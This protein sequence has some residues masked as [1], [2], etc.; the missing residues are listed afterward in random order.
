MGEPKVLAVLPYVPL[1]ATSGGRL[2]TLGLLRQLDAALP[3]TVLA[4]NRRP[5]T[6][7]RALAQTLRESLRGSL[8]V[9]ESPRL[10]SVLAGEASDVLLGRPLRYSPYRRGPLA[11]ALEALLRRER[12]DIVHFDHL[13]TAQ[14]APV[15]RRVA[16]WATVVVDAHN[17]ESVVAWRMS[18]ADGSRFRKVVAKAQ[19]RRIEW[20]ERDV[21]GQADLVLTC[22]STDAG[23]LSHL[24]ARETLV[25]PNGISVDA[26]AAFVEDDV[27][28]TDVVFVA[29]CDWWPNADAARR[30]VVEIWPR[31]EKALKG[32]R[33]TLV[34][35]ASD[36]IGLL[37]TPT[38]QLLGEVTRVEPHLACAWA[39]AVPLRAGSG[40]RIKIIEA[41]AAGVPVV[42]SKV[43]AEG[44]PLVEG[45]NG[46]FAESADEFAAALVR[47]HENPLLAGRL[48]KEGLRTAREFQYPEIGAAL[49][50]HYRALLPAA[51]S[52]SV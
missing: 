44:L 25:V 1:P 7:T 4:L 36:K 11:R 29:S 45:E 40:T 27:P 16:P 43:A 37:A 23:E 13:H 41:W 48:R 30:L 52:Q 14:L 19:A 21:L 17:V 33:L 24:G 2:R 34:G 51:E 31:C 39:T 20:L 15:V 35:R 3:V 26:A 8:T 42:A 9:A 49:V 28:R 6:A 38:I 50:R 10:P 22:S 47:I 46:L 5:G 18:G 12:F 32:S